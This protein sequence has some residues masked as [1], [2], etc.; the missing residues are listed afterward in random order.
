MTSVH[1]LHNY[2]DLASRIDNYAEE[3]KLTMGCRCESC[4]C[5]TPSSPYHS[6]PAHPPAS[7]SSLSSTGLLIRRRPLRKSLCHG[8]CPL[9]STLGA[10][11]RYL[12]GALASFP[13]R[14]RIPT[15]WIALSS[16]NSG[17]EGCLPRSRLPQQAC[18]IYSVGCFPVMIHPGFGI[19]SRLRWFQ[20]IRQAVML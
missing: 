17:S 3:R 1:T 18:S 10:S 20:A 8:T 19:E 6:I 12:W 9:F 15:S 11:A 2:Q 13:W 16:S 5:S 14:F 4:Y 7:T